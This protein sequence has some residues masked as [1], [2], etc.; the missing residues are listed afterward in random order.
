MEDIICLYGDRKH[1][2]ERGGNDT[3]RE[4]LLEDMNS[5]EHESLEF[6]LLSFL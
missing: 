2:T 5:G 4:E 1:S 3:G 6:T